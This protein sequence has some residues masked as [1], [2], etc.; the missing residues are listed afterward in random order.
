MAGRHRSLDARERSLVPLRERAGDRGMA[1][2]IAYGP[3]PA[4]VHVDFPDRA[5]PLFSVVREEGESRE[6]SSGVRA[7]AFDAADTSMC[8]M[9]RAAS[10]RL[11]WR[12]RFIRQFGKRG[13]GHGEL[14]APLGLAATRHG[15]IVVSVVGNRAWI[16]FTLL[17]EHVRNDRFDGPASAFRAPCMPTLAG[18]GPGYRTCY[19]AH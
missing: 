9:R 11:R 3:A 17:G 10:D 13:G 6:M 19:A 8:W 18:S 7:P 12:G 4:K 14:Q 16:I 2:G 1:D 5:T 15:S